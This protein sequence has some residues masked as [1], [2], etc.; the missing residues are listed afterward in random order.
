MSGSIRWSAGE[1]DAMRALLHGYGT[2]AATAGEYLALAPARSRAIQK[3]KELGCTFDDPVHPQ[4]LVRTDIACW[5]D[6]LE[7]PAA[8][9][10]TPPPRVQVYRKTA[11]TQDLARRHAGTW[12]AALADEQSA[13][14]GRL[15][16]P[17]TAP[18]GSCVLLSLA[19]PQTGQADTLDSAWYRVAL[20]VA[21]TAERFLGSDAGR[22]RIKWPNDIVIEERKLA[23]ILIERAGPAM[24]IGIG[25][26]VELWPQQVP[27]DLAERVTSLA[28]LGH[29]VDRLT[30]AADLIGRC[31]RLLSSPHRRLLLDEWRLR[32]RLGYDAQFINRG[33]VIAGTVLDLDPDAGLIVRRNTG[34]I[35]TL[36]AATTTTVLR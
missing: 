27:S 21:E 5:A 3:L 1:L 12:Y 33:E 2:T 23:G 34:E 20:A 13:G 7:S 31:H 26:N 35:V 29:P 22:V 10:D 18:P 24:I 36:P 28:M 14:R 15:G 16:R 25:F 9:D 6:Y 11:S 30:V 4:N 32:S 19:W 17:W 8:Y